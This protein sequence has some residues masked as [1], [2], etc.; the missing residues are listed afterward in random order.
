[1][2]EIKPWQYAVLGIGVLALVWVIY[3]MIRG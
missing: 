2:D 1:M 3:S